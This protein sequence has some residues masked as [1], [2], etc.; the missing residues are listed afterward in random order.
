MADLDTRAVQRVLTQFANNE[1]SPKD[2]VRS[3]AKKSLNNM[4]K[5]H[6]VPDAEENLQT[7]M[8]IL[9]HR[10]G[11]RCNPEMLNKCSSKAVSS[12]TLT[13]ATA[14]VP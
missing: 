4:V 14:I 10:P 2:S 5:E 7:I 8:A 11:A 13:R 9:T 1:Q 6:G 12:A 3:K